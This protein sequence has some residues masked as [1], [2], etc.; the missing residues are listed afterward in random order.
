[1]GQ[2]GRMGETGQRVRVCV[3]RPGPHAQTHLWCGFAC[4]KSGFGPEPP[5]QTFAYG[6]SH[7]S[8]G[9]RMGGGVRGLWVGGLF[10]FWAIWPNV[11]TPPPG[12]GGGS[13]WVG[14]QLGRGWVGPDSPEL[15]G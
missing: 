8:G 6:R 12:G 15:S 5:D 7:W 3:G 4:A 13:G 1:M 9:G 10:W 2:W 14:G 11:P